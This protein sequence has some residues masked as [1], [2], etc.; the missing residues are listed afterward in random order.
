MYVKRA[1][2]ELYNRELGSRISTK[3]WENTITNVTAIQRM[4][5]VATFRLIFCTTGPGLD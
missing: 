2:K 1:I 3:D 4:E 5:A